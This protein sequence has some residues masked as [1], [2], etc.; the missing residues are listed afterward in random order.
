MRKACP[1]TQ[2]LAFT[3]SSGK[4]DLMKLKPAYQKYLLQATI[5]LLGA[6]F[7]FLIIL[8]VATSSFH[9]RYQD[10]IYSGVSI[11][12]LDLSAKTRAEAAALLGNTYTYPVTGKIIFQDQNT[13][14]ETTPSNLGLFFSADLNA[15]EAYQVGRRGKIFDKWAAKLQAYRQGVSIPPHFVWDARVAHQQLSTLGEEINQPAIEAELRLDGVNIIAQEGQTGRN[16]DIPTTLQNLQALFQSQQNETLPLLITET[17]PEIL[18][19]SEQ[20]AFLEEI[21]RGSLVLK[22]PG[23]GEGDTGPW[24][25]S[26][27][28]LAEMLL[29]ERIATP[30]GS[31]Y[32]VTFDA[33]Y[34]QGILSDIARQVYRSEKNARFIFN[35]ETKELEVI[36]QEVIGRTLNIEQTMAA[37]YESL[38]NGEHIVEL[39]MIYT[40]PDVTSAHTAQDLG[41]MG[42]LNAEKTFFYYS[43]PERIH[44]IGTAA[45]QFH[46]VLVAPGET[47]SMG[48]T[49]GAVSAETG[50][51]EAWIIAGNRT[52]KGVGGGVCQVSTTLFRTVFFA[53]LPV[54][55]RHYHAYRVNY[56]EQTA[57]GGHD[58]N[59][60]G[61][62]ATVYFPS[63]DFKFTNDTGQW[64]L[65]ETYIN[66]PHRT[67]TWKFYGAQDGRTVDWETTGLQNITD[68]PNPIYIENDDFK[69]GQIEQTDWPAKGAD[70]TAIRHVYRGGQKLWT[71]TFKTHYSPWAAVCEYGP[72]TKGMPPK[73]IN[74]NN[75]C[76]PSG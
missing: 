72:G 40:E 41:I 58:P 56:Y 15:E 70:V 3:E 14:W 8:L 45:A 17:P 73:K 61:L 63:V 43:S 32:T 25:F 30:E 21:L 36:R 46:G 5:A 53:G 65:M 69:K 37:I 49:L 51:K 23:T 57:S 11:G 38:R 44:N 18:E 54:N 74:K 26:P 4:I 68:P 66:V 35:D 13:V 28:T 9:A 64:L 27:E 62:D 42:L 33:K 67:L 76:K 48:E 20:A 12:R 47:F 52:V 34:W 55:E 39:V 1:K 2:V 29:I 6:F 16:L 19:V 71:D 31:K 60:A 10:L 7:L 75:P 22:V 59:L 24:T 50:Y